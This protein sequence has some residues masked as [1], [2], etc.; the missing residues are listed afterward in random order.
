MP[1]F[2]DRVLS[3][4][5]ETQAYQFGEANQ[6]DRFAAVLLSGREAGPR[7]RCLRNRLA[8]KR[9][10]RH[11]NSRSG[12]NSCKRP[13]AGRNRQAG[14]RS[15]DNAAAA[16]PQL[17]LSSPP[18]AGLARRKQQLEELTGKEDLE[19]ELARLSESFRKTRD[20]ARAGVADM[21]RNLPAQLCRRGLR[22][23]LA[24]DSAGQSFG[25]LGTNA[26]LRCVR[27]AP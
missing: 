24:V 4:L 22:R 17:S 10:W 16:N 27:G 14:R 11:G 8:S 23:T 3:G 20:A 26:L 1:L 18:E 15:A 12:G 2:L 25:I 19:R 13:R 7:S 6:A 21:I 5:P 9:L